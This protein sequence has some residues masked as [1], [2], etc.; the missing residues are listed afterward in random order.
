MNNSKGQG[1]LCTMMGILSLCL[2]AFLIYN[3]YK[4]DR[5]RDDTIHLVD[6]FQS[7]TTSMVTDKEQRQKLNESFEKIKER[8]RNG[9]IHEV[10]EIKQ[11]YIKAMKKEKG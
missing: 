7:I 8:I 3:S 1:C 2:I 10:E 11:H 9:D 5:L 4:N 6:K